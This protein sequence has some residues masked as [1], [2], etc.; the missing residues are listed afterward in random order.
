[1]ESHPATRAVLKPRALSPTKAQRNPT[2]HP[3][4][5]FRTT[6]PREICKVRRSESR[7]GSVTLREIA[8]VIAL[9]AVGLRVLPHPLDFLTACVLPPV[10]FLTRAFPFLHRPIGL[11]GYLA[12]IAVTFLPA[13]I[14]SEPSDF[15]LATGV[16]LLIAPTVARWMTWRDGTG[17]WDVLDQIVIASAP[18][19]LPFTIVLIGRLFE[20]GALS[21]N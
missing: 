10:Y 19:A 14:T 7:P 17:R 12:W 8:V 3:R 1:M 4:F 5:L 18:V 6:Y 11:L 21:W 13:W 15:T 2:A 9:V 20:V 16:V